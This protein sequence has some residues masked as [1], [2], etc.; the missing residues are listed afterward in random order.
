MRIPAVPFRSTFTVRLVV[1]LECF[2]CNVTPVFCV[3]SR[4]EYLTRHEIY[5]E[6]DERIDSIA[7]SLTGAGA[8]FSNLVVANGTVRRLLAKYFPSYHLDFSKQT[9]GTVVSFLLPMG[10]AWIR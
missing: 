1:G 9:Q 7:W 3:A 4:G 8:F 2:F 10:G 5:D 6:R